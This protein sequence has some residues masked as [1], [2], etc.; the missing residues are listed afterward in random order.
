VSDAAL[1]APHRAGH[2]GSAG[3]SAAHR[4]T[5]RPAF[6]VR[7]VGTT[8][9]PRALM[10]RYQRRALAGDVAAATIAA[11]G[12]LGLRFGDDGDPVYVLLSVAVPALWVGMLAL[13]R[14]YEQRFLGRGLDEYRRVWK[15]A[16]LL[17]TTVA[18]ASYSVRADVARGYLFVAM[19]LTLVLTL[20]WRHH[21]RMWISRLRRAGT[22][23]H[24]VLVVG[25]AGA[26]Q[27][28]VERLEDDPWQGLRPVGVVIPAVD[29][30]GAVLDAV[31][32][33]DA[34]VV[35]VVSHPEFSG[36]ALRR[37]GWALEERQVELLLHPGLV[38]VAGPRLSIHPLADLCLLHVDRTRPSR[39]R[40][41]SKFVFDRAVA[42]GL[43]TAALP[44]LVA[45]A[46]AVRCTSPGP[47]LFRQ[48]RVG[49][50]GRP[51]T[52]LKFRSMVADAET[53]LIDLRDADE[54]NGVLFKVRADPRVTRVGAVLRR[55]SLDE[56]PQLLNVLRGDMSLVGPRPPLPREV[57]GYAPDTLRRLRMRPGLTGLWQVSGRSDLTWEQSVRLD[58]RYVDNWSMALDLSILFRTW[59]AVVKGA[60]AY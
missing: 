57:A 20:A 31:E 12:A 25:R 53:R 14:G 21:L 54:G 5:H 44:L 22:G 55:Y 11:F 43:L 9:D 18:V 47:V 19:P 8:D 17:F 38:E 48:T 56:L 51:F 42:L 26:A 34:H 58:L 33:L 2:T 23:A 36:T 39:V 24:R 37:L 30:L 49:A 40:L 16:L 3:P 7:S 35:A 32:E 6:H 29:D 59:R 15:A 28:L 1:A 60:G 50:D 10:L 46:I 41:A 4:D 52:M 45:I 13:E 27:S